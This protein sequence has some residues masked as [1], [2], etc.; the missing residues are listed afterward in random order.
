MDVSAGRLLQHMA[1]RHFWRVRV[2]VFR[3]YNASIV[4]DDLLNKD[5]DAATVDE[6]VAEYNRANKEARV[7]RMHATPCLRLA[8]DRCMCTLRCAP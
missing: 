3:T 4:L 2:Q 5:S 6:R 7:P 8:C 1:W